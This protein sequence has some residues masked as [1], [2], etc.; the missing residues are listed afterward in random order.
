MMD[1]VLESIEPPLRG[2]IITNTKELHLPTI[3]IIKA[4]YTMI[5]T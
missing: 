1:K 5:S 3:L 2:I 4:K